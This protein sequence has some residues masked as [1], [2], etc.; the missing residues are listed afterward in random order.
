MIL[1]RSGMFKQ[2]VHCLYKW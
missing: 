2:G 1:S